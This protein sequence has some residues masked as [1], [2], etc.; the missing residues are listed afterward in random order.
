[1]KNLNK[2]MLVLSAVILSTVLCVPLVIAAYE[3]HEVTVWTDKQKYAAGEKGTLYIAFYNNRDVAVTIENIT[4]TYYSWMAYTGEK[5]VGNETQTVNIPLSAK[6]TH[7]FDDITFTVPTDGRAVSTSAY[8]E[9]GTDHGYKY[10]SGSI[11]VPEVP[12]YMEQIVTLLT[13]LVVLVIVCTIIIAATI[14][15]SARRPQVTW[16]PQEKTE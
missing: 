2:K 11:N 12:S 6:S 8:V 5:W 7:V 14:F 1:V 13:I 15:L 4:I 10:G 9:I 3:P 16:R